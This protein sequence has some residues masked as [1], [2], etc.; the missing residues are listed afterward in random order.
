M[1]K[2]VYTF[3]MFM[4]YLY[5]YV[6]LS[7]FHIAS[8]APLLCIKTN[9]QQYLL[10]WRI[11]PALDG[12]YLYS[13]T[14]STYPG[15]NGISTIVNQCTFSS[16]QHT[17]VTTLAGLWILFWGKLC[18]TMTY[19]NYLSADVMW[20]ARLL[21]AHLS[22]IVSKFSGKRKTNCLSITK[23]THSDPM[24]S[25]R[26]HKKGIFNDISSSYY[27]KLLTKSLFL[28][29]I[30]TDIWHFPDNWAITHMRDDNYVFY[31]KMI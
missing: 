22:F 6:P 2:H 12:I 25:G 4:L 17:V 5:L 27:S 3:I 9:I 23:L 29:E 7:I 16:S 24:I 28:V 8:W 31:F 15:N 18:Y 1:K 13:D 10:S 19:L 14:P 11:Y 30:E 20:C 21:N 26:N